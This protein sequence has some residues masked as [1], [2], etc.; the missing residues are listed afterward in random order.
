M[1]EL[2]LGVALARFLDAKGY[3]LSEEANPDVDLSLFKLNEKIGVVLAPEER[4]D[5]GY[6]RAFE[7]AMQ[8]AVYA[9]RAD[10]G[11]ALVLGVDFA[12]TAAGRKPSY[13]RALKKYSNSIVFEDLQLSVLLATS[14]AEIIELR[15]DQVNNFFINLDSWIATKK[16]GSKQ[17]RK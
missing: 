5:A 7:A 4:D 15:P 14:A 11:L 2:E 3:S 6:L 8:K 16:N 1:E 12:A 9:R 13:R 17:K 10:T